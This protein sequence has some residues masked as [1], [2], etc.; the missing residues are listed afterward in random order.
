MHTTAL[1]CKRKA[2][3]S[4]EDAI[5]KKSRYTTLINNYHYHL[6]T[7]MLILAHVLLTDP[8]K[9]D[10]DGRNALHIVCQYSSDVDITEVMELL[11]DRYYCSFIYNFIYIMHM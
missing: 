1:C 3:D 4:Y 6:I 7:F 10:E 11:I 2:Y 5:R 8:N 9:K